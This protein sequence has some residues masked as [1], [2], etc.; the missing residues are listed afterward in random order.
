[1][2]N[3]ISLQ[4]YNST[5]FDEYFEFLILSLFKS[6]LQNQRFGVQT[7]GQT[8]GH[9][10]K[11]PRGKSYANLLNKQF[12]LLFHVMFFKVTVH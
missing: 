7:I 12:T 9:C 2:L 11:Y 10:F 3:S 1:M 4:V 5:S 6:T 8:I